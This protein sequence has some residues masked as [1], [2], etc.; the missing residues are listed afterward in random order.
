MLESYLAGLEAGCPVDPERLIAAHPELAGPLR[1]C[2]KVMHLA[3]GVSGASGPP[4]RP[5]RPIPTTPRSPSR[6]NP[7]P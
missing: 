6:R 1:A 7:V 2:L 5:Y 4:A 3:A